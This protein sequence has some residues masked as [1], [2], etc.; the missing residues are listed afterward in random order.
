MAQVNRH[1][2][3]TTN[4]T[5]HSDVLQRNPQHTSRRWRS[6]AYSGCCYNEGDCAQ[7]QCRC[8]KGKSRSRDC[9]HHQHRECD[10]DSGGEYRETI[11]R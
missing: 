9:A 1:N 6:G 7:S 8:R 5:K 10:P 4:Q 2:S 11:K 3:V